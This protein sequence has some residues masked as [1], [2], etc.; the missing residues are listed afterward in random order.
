MP[1]RRQGNA[2]F[3][4]NLFY[5]QSLP[6]LKAARQNRLSQRFVNFVSS[7]FPGYAAQFHS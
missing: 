4:G 5:L 7:S 2:Q 3:L 6:G 1:H